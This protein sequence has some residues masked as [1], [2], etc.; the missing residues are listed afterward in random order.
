MGSV[1]LALLKRIID[2]EYSGIST[3]SKIS[4]GKLRAFL[5]DGS[6]VDVWFSQKIPGDFHIIGSELTKDG[7]EIP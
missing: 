2:L 6:F 3:D 5:I 4:R 7:A 1:D